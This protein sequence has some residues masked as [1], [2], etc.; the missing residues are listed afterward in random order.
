MTSGAKRGTP[1]P[2]TAQ[3]RMGESIGVGTYRRI[4]ADKKVVGRRKIR[5]PP[6]YAAVLGVRP[7][8]R[9]SG[10]RGRPEAARMATFALNER[11][12]S[13][14]RLVLCALVVGLIAP[15]AAAQT[16]KKHLLIYKKEQD[17]QRHCAD[18]HVVWASTKSHLLYLPGDKHYAH[19]HGGYVCEGEA[20]AAG[21]HGPTAHS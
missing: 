11:G 16:P 14:T 17:A 6:D 7:W 3:S 21:Y 2:V 1:T 10:L 15:L 18:D 4:G 8:R 19:T 13:M 5:P 12:K 9:S 20:R